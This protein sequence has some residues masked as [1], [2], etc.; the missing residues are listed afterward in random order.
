MAT[1]AS[2]SAEYD[3]LYTMIG[4]GRTRDKV[5]GL[6][7]SLNKDVKSEMYGQELDPD[8]SSWI[9][10]IKGAE[11]AEKI[12]GKRPAMKSRRKTLV[13]PVEITRIIMHL[14]E[15]SVITSTRVMILMTTNRSALNIHF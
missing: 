8:K 11:H 2:L 9:E 13:E 15:G 14:M 7:V 12:L 6:W 3:Q 10:V 5:L 1:E 4:S